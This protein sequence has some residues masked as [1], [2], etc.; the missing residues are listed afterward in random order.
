MRR[1]RTLP[2]A[3]AAIIGLIWASG[4]SGEQGERIWTLPAAIAEA[5]ANSPDAII[6]R[7]RVEA[8]RGI[9]REV[10][11]AWL[12]Q[13]QLTSGYS[14]TDQPLMAFGTILNT[15]VFA[16]GIDFNRPGQVDHFHASATIA[17]NL[18]SGGTPTAQR[19]AARAGEEVARAD[20][21]AAMATLSLAVVRGY[22]GILQTRDGVA[23][24]DSAV[25][26]LRESQ[27][28]ARERFERG[29]LLRGELLNI[30][31]Q[32]VDTEVQLM[33]AENAVNLAERAFLVLLGHEPRGGVSLAREEG[34]HVV[35]P[36]SAQ[37]T[38]VRRPE[39]TAMEARLDAAEAQVDA[40]RGGGRPAL[41]LF[42][43]YQ[44]DKGW[45]M[46]GDGD[47]WVAGLRVSWPIFDGGRTRG[48]VQRSLA[49]QSQARAA[50]RKIDLQLQLQL[51][52]ARLA[53]DLAV[54]QLRMTSRLVDQAEESA[55][56]SR[57]RF[58][59]GDLLA[60]ELIGAETRLTE[61][62]MRRAIAVANER[63]A[64]AEL[65]HATGLSLP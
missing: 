23:A 2:V 58:E 33:A 1:Q 28:V 10:S 48:Q 56:I 22:Y 36:T 44:F 3:L 7:E 65:R 25:A 6:A 5:Q 45:R 17:Y 18:Y 42:A 24:L 30:E 4:L 60:T 32:L 43:T 49:E 59:A 38:T 27:R 46:R 41:D 57:A 19:R 14:Q 21:E 31:V 63:V 39:R 11:A 12:P 15:G 29:Q 51:E 34:S 55:S 8:A 13:V 35:L 26:V 54:N 16:P 9:L 47:S 40:A 52:Q 20:H 37:L 50:Q 53:H 64:V 62:R 61:A